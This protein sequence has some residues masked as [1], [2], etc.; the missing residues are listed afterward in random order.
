VS[1]LVLLILAKLGGEDG[2]KGMSEWVKLRATHLAHL[3]HLSRVSMPHQTTYERVLDALDEVEVAQVI[4]AFFA[5]AQE[6]NVTISIDGKVL[7]GTIPV[8]ESQ[9]THRLAAYVLER[10]VVLM[11]IEVES[12]ANEI[13]PAPC[14]LEYLDLSGC[15]VTGDALFTQSDLGVQIVEAGGHFVFP[16]KANQKT[17][18]QAI[19]DGFMPARVAQ[20]HQPIALAEAFVETT[21]SGHGRIEKRYLTVS[22]ALND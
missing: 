1:L 13:V 21:S 4:G 10:G 8:G 7:G 12:K 2:M 17:L 11:Q 19:A 20:A 14:L 9:G 15:G 16:V 5:Q 6:A 3:L 22:S 18:Q